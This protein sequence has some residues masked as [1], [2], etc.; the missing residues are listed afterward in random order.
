MPKRKSSNTPGP[1]EPG[2]EP[3]IIQTTTLDTLSAQLLGLT[4]TLAKTQQEV[5]EAKSATSSLSLTNANLRA[6]IASAKHSAD[7][8][9]SS[10]KAL[11][12]QLEIQRERQERP[13]AFKSKGNEDQYLIQLKQLDLNNNAWAAFKDGRPDDLEVVL[14]ATNA[15]ILER[16]KHIKYAEESP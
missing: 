9:C 1:V 7:E 15:A 5:Q 12:S 14:K 3:V 6:D 16:I 10:N 4:S 13:I 8:A 11:R 2:P